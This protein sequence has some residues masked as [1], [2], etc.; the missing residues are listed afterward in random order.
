MQ[1]GPRSDDFEQPNTVTPAERF[2][3]DMPD[4]YY[5][6]SE[7]AELCSVHPNTLRR[8]LKNPKIKA[9]SKQMTHGGFRM[10]LY[11]LE[12][13]EELREYFKEKAWA[14]ERSRSHLGK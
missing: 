7:A 3:A 9:P 12:D 14:R 8:L 4:T 10:Y 6:L 1:I 5:R 13:I 2:L 11:T